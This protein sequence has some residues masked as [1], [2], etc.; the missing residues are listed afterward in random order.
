MG[1]N[2]GQ[3]VQN[4]HVDGTGRGSPRYVVGYGRWGGI[5]NEQIFLEAGQIGWERTIENYVMDIGLV[6]KGGG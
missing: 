6:Q 5:A 4:R 2:I 3:L 1:Y